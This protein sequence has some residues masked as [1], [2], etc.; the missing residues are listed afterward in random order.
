MQDTADSLF[1][2]AFRLCD[3]LNVV[4]V[5]VQVNNVFDY[6][7]CGPPYVWLICIFSNRDL[8]MILFFF[9][10]FLQYISKYKE[11]YFSC[12]LVVST[13]TNQTFSFSKEIFLN[14][15]SDK[16]ILKK[17]LHVCMSSDRQFQCS[18]RAEVD[19]IKLQKYFFGCNT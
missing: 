15:F 13:V 4:R 6:T 3:M 1:T 9:I 16:T 5:Q 18:Q 10:C 19:E 2:M 14:C 17:C 8:N 12:P 7:I 11:K